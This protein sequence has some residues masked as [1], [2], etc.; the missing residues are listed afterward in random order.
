M[1]W[2][3]RQRT[4][5]RGVIDKFQIYD[6]VI[7]MLRTKM[8][9]AGTPCTLFSN[10][11]I[12]FYG[13]APEHLTKC[14]CWG[15][16]ENQPNRSHF[17]CLGTGY[18]EGYQR[19]GY[20]EIVVSTPST[21]TKDAS[22][23]TTQV[24]GDPEVYF[25]ISSP[26]VTQGIITTQ[27]LS[28]TRCRAFDRFI[29]NDSTNSAQNS[30]RYYYTIDNNTWIE[31]PMTTYNTNKLGTRQGTFT[32]PQGTESIKFRIVLQKR[33]ANSPSP[34]FNSLRFRYR[35]QKTLVEMDPKF[36]INEAAFLAC[37]EQQTI[38]VKQGAQGWETV[39]PLRWW[40]LPE[41][42]IKDGDLIKFL[43]GFMSNQFY[44]VQSTTP[45]LHGPT[46]KLL[47]TSF[48]SEYIR[49]PN[50]VIKIINLLS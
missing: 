22:V 4:E 10:S 41:V 20:E 2:T 24:S 30:I 48:E 50:D 3:S 42:A 33:Y 17:L 13:T 45:H 38:E 29:V 34:K 26:S 39:R 31:I 19:Y 35:N 9:G 47:H 49:D 11:A 43:T 14:Y 32:L 16:Q 18:L 44:E 46:T 25:V 15:N 28:L 37:R 23:I 21:V 5:I 40:T 27:S 6:H 12:S 1:R 8:R 7:S 36:D